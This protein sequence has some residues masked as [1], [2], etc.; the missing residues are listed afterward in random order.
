VP[1]VQTSAAPLA[2]LV[3]GLSNTIVTLAYTCIWDL[4]DCSGLVLASQVEHFRSFHGHQP[5]GTDGQSM[6]G[7]FGFVWIVLM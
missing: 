2:L 4:F 1:E 6:D 3:L 5:G 7:L